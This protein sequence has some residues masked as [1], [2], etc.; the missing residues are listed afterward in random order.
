V[1]HF[2]SARTFTLSNPTRPL[3]AASAHPVP[4]SLMCGAPAIPDV[5]P[6]SS[7]QQSA[8]LQ[9]QQALALILS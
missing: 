1:R 2:R 4:T 3:C 6:G 8:S 7:F 9:D 5:W